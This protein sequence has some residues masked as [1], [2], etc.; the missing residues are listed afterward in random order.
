MFHHHFDLDAD[1]LQFS[2]SFDIGDLFFRDNEQFDDID[3][4]QDNQDEQ[5]VADGSARSS[6]R[7]RTRRRM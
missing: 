4:D 3:D 6:S 5:N 7:S 1:T 2:I